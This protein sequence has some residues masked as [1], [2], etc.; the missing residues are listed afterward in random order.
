MLDKNGEATIKYVKENCQMAEDHP[1]EN[2]YDL[3]EI[4]KP[5]KCCPQ[6]LRTSC[7]VDGSIIAVRKISIFFLF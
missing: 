7:K 5:D 6:I 2:D 1:D 4:S 3:I